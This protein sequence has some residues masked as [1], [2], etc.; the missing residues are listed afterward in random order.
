MAHPVSSV[1]VEPRRRAAPQERGTHGN[2]GEDEGE[3]G[4]RDCARHAGDREADE[5]D[6]GLRQPRADEAVD[7]ALDR[8]LR[9]REHRRALFPA[10]Q[11]GHAVADHASR[12]LPVPVEEEGHEDRDED[13]QE[14]LA[15]GGA[16]GDEQ[17]FRG[18]GQAPGEGD[19]LLPAADQAAPVLVQGRTYEGQ[20]GEP[21]GQLERPPV[22]QPPHEVDH[23]G[24]VADEAESRQRHGQG[25]GEEHREHEKEGRQRRRGR[26]AG[27]GPTGR[28]A[29]STGRGWP[30]RAS[31]RE[32]AG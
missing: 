32:T 7:D 15:G 17:P 27:P 9:R 1:R 14:P 19:D 22:D 24:G 21:G 20:A 25:D 16:G 10:R 5:C 4:K 11:A 8:A 13:V 12:R 28:P 30:R 3:R 6:G 29:R 26:R 23:L 2:E 31:R 18:L